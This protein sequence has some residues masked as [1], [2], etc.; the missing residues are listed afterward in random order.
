MTRLAAIAWAGLI[1][2]A[3][4]AGLDEGTKAEDLVGTW[5][6]VSVSKGGETKSGDEVSGQTC[7]FTKETLTQELAGM[8]FAY[9]FTVDATKNPSRIALEVTDSP[10]GAGSKADG[11]I[12]VKGDEMKLAYST[13]GGRPETFDP[14]KA[15]ADVR[16]CVLKRKK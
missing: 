12:E 10:F 7:V 14:D 9:K 15:G 1:A 5:S 4:G 3:G 16:I 2:L 13:E 8:R 6:M 11:I